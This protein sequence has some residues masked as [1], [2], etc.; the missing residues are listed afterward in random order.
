M[1]QYTESEKYG[2]VTLF[3]DQLAGFEEEDIDTGSFD[4]YGENEDGVE[5]SCTV[6]IPELAEESAEVIR[7]LREE[8]GQL[9]PSYPQVRAGIE[10]IR[11]QMTEA[12]NYHLQ[13]FLE[14]FS[15]DEEEEDFLSDLAVFTYQAMR[16]KRNK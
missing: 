9:M 15:S 2:D 4:C 14:S 5:G 16:S 1:K 8:N 13:K 12:G 6:S 11:Q 7:K 3:L 10:E